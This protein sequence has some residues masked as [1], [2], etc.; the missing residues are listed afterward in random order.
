MAPRS[1]ACRSMLAD[2]LLLARHACIASGAVE[3]SFSKILESMTG[4]LFE[5]SWYAPSFPM[6]DPSIKR[7]HAGV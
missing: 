6:G 3:I 7:D 2:R 1:D 4:I 5:S